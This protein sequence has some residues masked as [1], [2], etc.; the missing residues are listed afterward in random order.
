MRDLAAGTFPRG[1]ETRV[2]RPLLLAGRRGHAASS[3]RHPTTTARSAAA[4]ASSASSSPGTRGPPSG[5][6]RLWPDACTAPWWDPLFIVCLSLALALLALWAGRN[7][8]TVSTRRLS[9][10]SRCP[11]LGA[12]ALDRSSTCSCGSGSTAGRRG[13]AVRGGRHVGQVA[14]LR[15]GGG[16]RRR[17][18]ALAAA[19]RRSSTCSARPT[20]EPGRRRPRTPPP[21]ESRF[22]LAF[23]GGGVRAA[24]ISLGALQ[25][26]ERYGRMGWDCADHVTSVSGG[27]YMA[28]AWSLARSTARADAAT[29]RPSV[30]EDPGPTGRRA[31]PRRRGATPAG[32]P[33]LPPVQHPARKRRRHDRAHREPRRPTRA[34]RVPAAVATVLTGMLVNAAV[35]LGMLWL[36]SQLLGIFYRWYFGLGLQCLPGR[37]RRGASARP[38]RQCME[39]SDRLVGPILVWLA[40]GLVSVLVWVVAAKATEVIGDPSPPAWLLALKYLGYGGLGLAAGLGILLGLLPFL[41]RSSGTR[42]KPTRSPRP[43]RRRRCDRVGRSRVP[44]ATPP[45]GEGGAGARR[46][47]VRAR[48]R[49]RRLL[50]G[51]R[52]DDR[53]AASRDVSYWVLFGLLVAVLAFVHFFGAIEFWSLAAFYRGKLRSA[54]ATYRVARQAPEG[55]AWNDVRAKAYVNDDQPPPDEYIEPVLSRLHARHVG[56]DGKPAGTPLTICASAT[57]TGRQVR[58][59]YGIP[60][61]SVTFSPEHVRMHAPLDQDGLWQRYECATVGHGRAATGAVPAAHDDDGRRDV[62]R[63]RV[64]RHGPVQ[65]RPDQHAAGVLQRPPGCWIP[66]PRY[67]ETLAKQNKRLPR[68]GLG[69]LLK[70][71]LGFHDP[72]TSTST[73]PTAGTGRTPRWSSCCA[74]AT[75]RRSCAWTPTPVPATSPS[76]SR[77]RSTSPRWSAPRTSRSTSMSPRRP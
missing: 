3:S 43:R 31:E 48:A 68:P 27:S 24:S 21:E 74:P 54:F 35:F 17:R 37:R 16:V 15:P 28:G 66:N 33:R 13:L 46:A 34:E 65:H 55:Q 10:R 39:V 72:A 61:L 9:S 60:A 40:V 76:R 8:R 58:T 64:A 52:S 36:L 20:R 23:C 14:D 49:L 41:L 77:R 73:S 4:P 45:A 19:P 62:G 18:P 71:F 29:P 22:G 53:C 11:A 42:S 63:G 12:L 75:T 26:L 6:S 32:Q 70:E 5:W 69:Y 59:H 50:L 7:Y 38:R 67:A 1:T 47:A 56:E 30:A 25:G 57:I 2:S 51:A 44:A